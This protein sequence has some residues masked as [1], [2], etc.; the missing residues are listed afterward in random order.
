MCQNTQTGQGY[1]IMNSHFKVVAAPSVAGQC[2]LYG[3]KFA[4]TLT[5]DKP[6]N[7]PVYVHF[8][9]QHCSFYATRS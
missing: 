2:N 7:H 3:E 8:A 6:S 4:G 1:S 9:T 5:Y